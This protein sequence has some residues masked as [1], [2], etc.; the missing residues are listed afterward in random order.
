VE[1]TNEVLAIE[2]KFHLKVRDMKQFLQVLERIKKA[3]L[4]NDV[5]WQ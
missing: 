2:V 5:L 1:N 3:L 4:A